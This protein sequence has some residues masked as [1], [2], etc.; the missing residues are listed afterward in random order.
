MLDDIAHARRRDPNHE[1]N[2]VETMA[3]LVGVSSFHHSSFTM[4]SLR[5]Q[6]F[7]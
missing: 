5:L 7:T 3:P 6:I 4:S 1:G 2:I